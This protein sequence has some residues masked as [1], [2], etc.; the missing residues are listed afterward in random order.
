MREEEETERG[1][2][3][4]KEGR[5]RRKSTVSTGRCH[6]SSTPRSVGAAMHENKWLVVWR[7]KRHSGQVA[8]G[9]R[10]TRC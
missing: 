8:S 6:R 4:E 2:R 3:E 1:A 10:P 5:D 7:R 9:A